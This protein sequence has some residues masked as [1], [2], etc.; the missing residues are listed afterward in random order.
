L[1]E[2]P[3]GKANPMGMPLMEPLLES[4]AREVVWWEPPEVTLSDTDDFICRVMARGFWEDAQHVERVFGEEAFRKALR[5]CKAGAM[6]AGS[7]HYWHYR[8]G[9][10]PVP[11]EPRRNLP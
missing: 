6:D 3:F 11:P 10:E 1:I 9:L 5:N 7:W 2:F 8:L 4:I